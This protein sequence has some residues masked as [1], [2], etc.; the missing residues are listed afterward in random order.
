MAR[1][2]HSQPM[3]AKE[4]EPTSSAII[5]TAR[6][7]ISLNAGRRAVTKKDNALPTRLIIIIIMITVTTD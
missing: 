7:T 2:K 1:K 3:D 5:A 6:G 4:T